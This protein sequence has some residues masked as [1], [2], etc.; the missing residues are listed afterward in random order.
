VRLC[1][2][3]CLNVR[4]LHILQ[5]NMFV[6]KKAPRVHVKAKTHFFKSLDL[7]ELM[8]PADDNP[9]AFTGVH[10]VTS[11]PAAVFRSGMAN[12]AVSTLRKPTTRSLVCKLAA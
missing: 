10:T 7:T 12:D 1:E 3:H 9:G 4:T 8:V 2:S 6:G 11:R 5:I